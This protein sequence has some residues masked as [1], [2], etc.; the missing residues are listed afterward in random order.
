MS[1]KVRTMMTPQDIEDESG[2]DRSTVYRLIASGDLAYI[3]TDANKRGG[4]IRVLRT[5]WEDWIAR[6]RTPAKASAPPSAAPRA[7][8]TVLDLPGATRYVS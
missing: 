2:F 4:A 8:E 7:K 1:D 5:D 6:H 3:R